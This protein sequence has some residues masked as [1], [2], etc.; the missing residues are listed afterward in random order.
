[1]QN[2]APTRYGSV[3]RGLPQS[4]SATSKRIVGGSTVGPLFS[5]ANR[6]RLIPSAK[7][8]RISSGLHGLLLGV[9]LGF[10]FF[11]VHQGVLHARS[12]S[13]LLEDVLGMAFLHGLI[14]GDSQYLTTRAA[15][16]GAK[17]P[18]SQ[19]GLVATCTYA[20]FAI[21]HK[22]FDR[23]ILDLQL[24]RFQGRRSQSYLVTVELVTA[25]E[26]RPSLRNL[27]TTTARRVSTNAAG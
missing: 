9:D 17:D 25:P 13:T 4:L 20:W 10:V 2:A 21:E 14:P 5:A 15:D 6:P 23:W 12:S 18:L 11:M 27:C 8:R 26:R 3:V 16:K 1:M 19:L 22:R 24:R 7:I